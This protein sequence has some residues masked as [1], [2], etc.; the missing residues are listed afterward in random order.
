VSE[1]GTPLPKEATAA[2]RY[3]EALARRVA[4]V[5]VSE[6]APRAILLT[7]SAATGESDYSSDV[8]M[9][10]YC[11]EQPGPDQRRAVRALVAVVLG[12]TVL[13]PPGRDGFLVDGVE[14][15]VG[16]PTVAQGE[17]WLARVLRDHAPPPQGNQKVPLGVLQGIPLHGEET[18]RRWQVWAASYPEPLAAVTVRHYV[19]FAPVWDSVGFLASR[20]ARL[21][22]HHDVIETL[23]HVLG[24]LAG[25]NRRYYSPVQFKRLRAFT[26]ALPHAPRNLADWIEQVLADVSE[27]P[28]AAATVVRA[29]VNETL[30]LV[31]EHMPHVDTSRAR[32]DLAETR[33][34]WAPV[35]DAAHRSGNPTR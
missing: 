10:V 22:F 31:E 17:E 29:L 11:E 30:G 7:G 18:I 12:A 27:R 19:R 5:Y 15:Q 20:D 35:G 21:S 4:A 32:R 26:A 9:L 14:C 6:L 1:P 3:L 16:V 34:P 13:D 8:D 25:L 33:R 2:S 24:V 28:A 23:Q